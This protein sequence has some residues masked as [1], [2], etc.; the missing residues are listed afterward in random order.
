MIIKTKFNIGEK[1]YCWQ[2]NSLIRTTITEIKATIKDNYK[3]VEYHCPKLTLSIDRENM[4]KTREEAIE[5]KKKEVEQGKIA[6][7]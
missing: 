7:S 1:I 5:A 3:S 6:E 2:H 4:Y